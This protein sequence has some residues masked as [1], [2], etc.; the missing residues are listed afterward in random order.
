MKISR[1]MVVIGICALCIV[2]G[3]VACVQAVP[4]ALGVVEPQ[5]AAPTFDPEKL[6]TATFAGGCFWSMQRM[7]DEVSGVITTTVGYSGGHVENPTYE[8]VN[9]ETTGHAESVEVIFDSSQISYEELVDAYWHDIDPVAVDQQFCD[10]GSSY[11]SI[12][13]Y[14]DAEQQQVA[15][16]SKKALEE[17]GRFS[18]PI[19]TEVVAASTFYPAE[20]YHQ[21]FYLKN[22]MHYEQYRIGCGRDAQLAQI[23]GTSPQ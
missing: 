4:P 3:L 10:R 2:F 9:T 16:A 14:H 11:R 20:E 8:M 17:S 15:E 19:V 12:I 21:K 7:M 5:A 18:Q 23:W 6:Q 13:F 22:P 1:S